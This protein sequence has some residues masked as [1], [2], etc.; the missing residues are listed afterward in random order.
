MM[1]TETRRRRIIAPAI[2]CRDAS[3]SLLVQLCLACARPLT[4]STRS[5]SLPYPLMTLTDTQHAVELP[6]Y[7]LL[8]GWRRNCAASSR[9]SPLLTML[10]LNSGDR[11]FGVLFAPV[12]LNSGSDA[13]LVVLASP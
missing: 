9:A 8:P 13:A 12:C 11:S 3:I 7:A 4:S 5:A 2:P 6:R 1:T 10:S